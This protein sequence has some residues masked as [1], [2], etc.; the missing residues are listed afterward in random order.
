MKAIVSLFLFIVV[1]TVEATPLSNHPL[2]K[3]MMSHYEV[4]L[5]SESPKTAVTKANAQKSPHILVFI[6]SN[7]CPYCVQFA[8]LV[9]AYAT[10]N[11]WPIEAVSLNG[12]ILPD[13]PDA[14][15]ATQDMI[16]VAYQ[17]KPVVYPA[18]F[19]A[20]T[21]TK[22]LYPVSFGALSYE[23]LL[24]RIQAITSK[25]KEHEGQHHD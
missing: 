24:E 9:K 1:Q 16:D 18:L 20:N 11:H 7:Q 25:I 5:K 17:G 23:E 14:I 6:F 15:F 12:Q 13:F 21:R 10:A 4:N 8:P 3:L 19:I 22:A 2:N